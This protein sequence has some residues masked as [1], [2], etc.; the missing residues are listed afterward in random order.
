VETLSD[1]SIDV[2]ESGLF[3]VYI[4][5]LLF[6]MRSIILWLYGISRMKCNEKVQYYSEKVYTY[7]VITAGTKHIFTCGYLPSWVDEWRTA[8][9]KIHYSS[10]SSAKAT[11]IRSRAVPT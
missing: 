5:I 2:N 7:S 10:T 6:I 4:V 9:K 8:V 1:T 3:V 11:P